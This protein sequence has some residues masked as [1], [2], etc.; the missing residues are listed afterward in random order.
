MLRSILSMVVGFLTLNAIV[1]ASGVTLQISGHLPAS[2]ADITPS[3]LAWSLG[4]TFLGAVLAGI[5][6]GMVAQRHPLAHAA[7]LAGT[8]FFI[9]IGYTHRLWIAPPPDN[10][11]HWY[12]LTLLLGSPIAIVLGGVWQQRR[13]LRHEQ[14]L[15]AEPQP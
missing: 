7:A 1:I 11:P 12:L 9:S 3:Y 2:A 14:P 10:P 13:M 8:V 6:C 4:F 15:A 5:V